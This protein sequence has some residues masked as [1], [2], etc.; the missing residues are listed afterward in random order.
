[1][2]EVIIKNFVGYVFKNILT[3]L[4]MS[5]KVS[6]YFETFWEIFKMLNLWHI[7]KI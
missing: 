6:K 4:K 5:H 7:F 3:I 2:C 1:M